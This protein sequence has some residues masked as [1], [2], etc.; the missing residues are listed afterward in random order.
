MVADVTET[1]Y[2]KPESGQLLLSP[3]DADPGAARRHPAR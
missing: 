1:F 3:A 2:F